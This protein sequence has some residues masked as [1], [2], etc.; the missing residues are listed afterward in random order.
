MN[1]SHIGQVEEIAIPQTFTKKVFMKKLILSYLSLSLFLV[2][3]GNKPSVENK[4]GE[5]A[6]EVGQLESGRKLYIT[7]ANGEN[8]ILGENDDFIT[9]NG[10]KVKFP[11]PV[12]KALFDFKMKEYLKQQL[13]S[14][15]I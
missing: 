13:N 4:Q 1:N 15:N 6:T 2:G 9:S 3:C 14:N 8:I 5:Q 7:G 10:K 12:V 11:R